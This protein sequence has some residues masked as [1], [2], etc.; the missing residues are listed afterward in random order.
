MKDLNK[1]YLYRMVHIENI[2][3]LLQFGITHWNSVN[4]NSNYIP[5]GDNSLINSR[6]FTRL[7][8]NEILGNYIPF[9][10][11]S[12]MPML[13]VIQKGYNEVP[14]TEPEKIVYCISTVQKI[15]D[16]Q[17]DFIFTDGHAVDKTSTIYGLND[18]HSIL[19][20]VDFDAIKAKYWKKETDLDLKRRKEVEFLVKTDI[21][22][23]GIS[24]YVVYSQTA[25]DILI[26]LNIDADKIVIRPTFYF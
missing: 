15:M 24:G 20:I 7:S 17:L 14:I 26:E 12:R 8:N 16:L 25:K 2:S 23:K 3:H 13:L 11:G 1:V 10:F 22:P 4:K 9:Y 21:P 5:I 18:V 19:N 6:N